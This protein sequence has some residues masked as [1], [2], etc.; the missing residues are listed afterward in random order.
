MKKSQMSP[1]NLLLVITVLTGGMVL[2][3]GCVP[4]GPQEPL[5]PV[6]EGDAKFSDRF[7]LQEQPMFYY[8]LFG[9]ALLE[10]SEVWQYMEKKEFDQK[11]NL[12]AAWD[13]QLETDRYGAQLDHT[14]LTEDT[15]RG[16][17]T[18]FAIG[19]A[20]RLKPETLFACPYIIRKTEF[21]GFRWD[22]SFAR[23]RHMFT[24]LNSR[25]SNPI[26][27]PRVIVGNQAL[28]QSLGR[29]TGTAEGDG[30]ATWVESAHL[31]G[32]R[33]QGMLGDI[34]RVGFTMIDISRR[35]PQRTDNPFLGSVPNTPPYKIVLTFRDDSPEDGRA[36][37][38]FG[39]M[40]IYITE[41][42]RDEQG[43]LLPPE[44][45][46]PIVV[47]YD[48]VEPSVLPDGTPDPD[49][50]GGEQIGP[51]TVAN[52]FDSFQYTLDLEALVDEGVIE[53]IRT[54]KSIEFEMTLAGDYY[55]E[56]VGYSRDNEGDETGP[57]MLMDEFGRIIM[58]FRDVIQAE[59][60][61]GQEGDFVASLEKR[62]AIENDPNKWNKKVVRYKYGAA[63]GAMLYGV[64]LEGTIPKI[65]LY[66]NAQYAV[67]AKFKQYPTVSKD[68]IDFGLLETY[69]PNDPTAKPPFSV[70]DGERFEA[71]LGGKN[72]DSYEKAW[73]IHLKGRFSEKILA[74]AS[75]Y[76]IDPGYTTTYLGLG[77]NTDR[78][79]TYRLPRTGEAQG[80]TTPPID[81]GNYWLIEDDDD[82]DDWPDSED[83]DG[84]LPMADDRDQNG[85]LDYQED[86]LLFEADP[87]IFSDIVDLNHNRVIDT[88][89]DDYEP[90]YPYGIDRK[91]FHIIVNYDV[92]ENLTLKLGWLNEKQV[93]SARQNNTKY[94]H[95]IYQR[96]I[97]DFGTI[98]F[99]N[100]FERVRDSIPDYSVTLYVGALEPEETM[101]ALDFYNAR[102][103]TTTLQ[104]M[105]TAIPNLTLETKYLLVLQK[106]Y[107]PSDAE[108]I[109]LDEDP[110]DE[111]DTRIDFR[112]PEQQV[113]ASGGLKEYPFYPDPNLIFNRANW[114]DRR[115]PERSI[116]QNTWI[117]KTK[118]EIPLGG[119]PLI[120]KLGEDITLT[121]M[122]KYIYIHNWDRKPEEMYQPEE[123][124]PIYALNYKF[125]G[126]THPMTDEYLRFNQNSREI[127]ELIRLDYQFTQRMTILGGFQ[128]RRFINKDKYFENYLDI[129][130]KAQGEELRVSDFYRPTV[131][132]R[133]LEI[134]AINRGEW[135][136]FN[137][138]V[139]LGFRHRVDLKTHVS[140]DTWFVRALM[141]F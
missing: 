26:R 97:P 31:M 137:V 100:R 38:A 6:V 58:P 67:N 132:T 109:R 140:A 47:N 68:N 34:F 117:F 46:P 88:L 18:E 9:R 127:V 55:V 72:N 138:V 79:E 96:D 131:K 75:F 98:R 40:K 125:Y 43:N 29:R 22:I 86:F 104:F 116:R 136:G 108:A 62:A 118:Y 106:Q 74:E 91:G 45:K 135:L 73:F 8:D 24:F 19:D 84:V 17:H 115:Y 33:A 103:N 53:D 56:I 5:M 107:E 60:N 59:G 16:R 54:V 37:A 129:F 3:S 141:G 89:E 123:G 92:L 52:G 23:E 76:H 48:E 121:P 111:I 14:I 11:G 71:K 102:I 36:G 64:D 85:I 82:N 7:E 27:L 50:T 44:K 1:L 139:L 110:T 32:L 87:P 114:K 133:I 83:F 130:R 120:G 4:L 20:L 35:H 81:E 30:A 93:S 25:I 126:P 105:Y 119:L 70:C 57:W 63:R 61:V 65:N 39:G 112:Y 21:D 13:G 10:G 122:F 2:L 95:I 113:E 134:Q 80:E 101:D 51:F 15:F 41:Q 99:Q 77:A 78:D 128:F 28:G 124:G 42:K 94:L 69:D 12:A 90:D 66:V 49:S